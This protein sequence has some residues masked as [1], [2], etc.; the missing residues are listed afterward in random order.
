LGYD[1]PDLFNY[2]LKLSNPSTIAQ[3]QKLDLWKTKLDIASSMPEGLGSKEFIRKVIWD[4]SD[5]ECK[6][7]D[8]QRMK[9][10][11]FDNAVEAAASGGG[12]AG[13]GGGGM[14]DM[15]GGGE[16]GGGEAA[17][18]EEP[19]APA[20]EENAGEE[21][22]DGGRKLLVSDDRDEIPVLKQD[23]NGKPVNVKRQAY[24]HNLKRRRVD[25]EKS[26]THANLGRR[27]VKDLNPYNDDTKRDMRSLSDSVESLP[28]MKEIAAALLS[29]EE[30][31]RPICTPDIKNMLES[32]SV[33]VK[34]AGK[35]AP[36]ILIEG[37]DVQDEIDATSVDV[38]P[39][40]PFIK[41]SDD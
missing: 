35:V 17:P 27:L 1:G 28:T 19:A 20:G 5:D 15:F 22:D 21:H 25:S 9:E 39:L 12:D 7:I 32:M 31:R 11:Q 40:K 6:K 41:L 29:A 18:A 30:N 26:D 34:R 24:M 36:D 38:L 13:G 37:I 16:A 4:L 33:V 10:K 3:L 14:D 8:D 23:D 2:S